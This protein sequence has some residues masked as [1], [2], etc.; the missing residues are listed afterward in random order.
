MT[1]S[2]ISC[3]S[4]PCLPHHAILSP[5][6]IT[7][8]SS[9]TPTEVPVKSRP[10][11]RRRLTNAPRARPA[12][13]RNHCLATDDHV[14]HI[15]GRLAI[16]K[17]C[18]IELAPG[19]MTWLGEGYEIGQHPDL[20]L[21]RLPAQRAH[22]VFRGRIQELLGLVKHAAPGG[23]TLIQLEPSRL[24]EHVDHRIR[25]AADGERA[26]GVGAVSYTHLTL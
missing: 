8:A 14:A 22:P 26:A 19:R 17:V 2:S 20:Q 3:G 15:A 16:D 1:A 5:S 7:A 18:G 24:F 23:A 9:I 21:S 12:S 25:V 11:L 6:Q 4:S 10:M 13:F